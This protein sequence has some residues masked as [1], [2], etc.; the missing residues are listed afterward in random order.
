MQHTKRL[1]NACWRPR[2]VSGSLIGVLLRFVPREP[3]RPTQNKLCPISRE[4]VELDI[5][6]VGC[7][8]PFRCDG[9]VGHPRCFLRSQLFP[10]LFTLTE[11]A[12][13][14]CH[15]KNEQYHRHHQHKRHDE[16][17]E[18]GRD[19]VRIELRGKRGGGV[20]AKHPSLPCV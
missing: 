3:G 19:L 1:E 11:A 13:S 17:P 8:Q 2:L 4:G 18:S 16:S 10:H 5:T 9:S 14:M 12:H 6:V 15:V 20:Q 7:Y